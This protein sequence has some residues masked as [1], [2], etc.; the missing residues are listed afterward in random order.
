MDIYKK[1]EQESSKESSKEIVM[2][3]LKNVLYCVFARNLVQRY[4]L[5]LSP[6]SK[7][8]WQWGVLE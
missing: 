7:T 1:G 8:C 5:Y 6:A 2:V 4:V 3:Y